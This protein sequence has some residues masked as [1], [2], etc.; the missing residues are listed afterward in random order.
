MRVWG[1]YF[2]KKRHRLKPVLR[3]EATEDGLHESNTDGFWLLPEMPGDAGGI[4][5]IILRLAAK[6]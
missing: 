5:E 2:R 1:D 4:I 3:M 6:M